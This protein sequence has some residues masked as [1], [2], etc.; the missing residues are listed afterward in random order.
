MDGQ[1]DYFFCGVGSGGSITGCSQYFRKNLPNTKV[2]GVDPD[3]SQLA[4]P[5]ELN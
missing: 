5:V 3:G 4:L 1:L 2:I